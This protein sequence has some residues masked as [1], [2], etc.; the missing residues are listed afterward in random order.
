MF[1]E[2]VKY[3]GVYV[4]SE[5]ILRIIRTADKRLTDV[6]YRRISQAIIGKAKV[7]SKTALRVAGNYFISGEGEITFLGL[8][9]YYIECIWSKPDLK[10]TIYYDLPKVK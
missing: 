10:L 7:S 1:D 6:G 4:V 8:P 5:N 3:K 2:I 9:C